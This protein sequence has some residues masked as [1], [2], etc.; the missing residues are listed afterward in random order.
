MA[1]RI[2]IIPAATSGY[3]AVTNA[4]LNSDAALSSLTTTKKD[5][6]DRWFR[7]L[8]GYSNPSYTTY[9]VWSRVVVLYPFIGGTSTS[10]GKNAASPGTYDM[11]HNGS[12]TFNANSI[13]YA[14]TAGA[15]QYSNTNFVCNGLTTLATSDFSGYAIHRMDT[16]ADTNATVGALGGGNSYAYFNYAS[17][18]AL[19]F[20]TN[21]VQTHPGYP[22]NIYTPSNSFY[23]GYFSGAATARLNTNGSLFSTVSSVFAAGPSRAML[24]GAFNSGTIGYGGPTT[25]DFYMSVK[26][27]WTSAEMI[28]VYTAT[29]TL[30]AVLG[31]TWN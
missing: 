13:S 5:A 15:A 12:P 16:N 24:I 30:K 23:A 2:I 4:Y 20:L 8:N 11:T 14:G 9:D 27:A 21:G 19:L 17:I 18:G 22:G 10:L 31:V 1:R 29:K 25:P 26:G 28:A 3:L 7:D 6:I